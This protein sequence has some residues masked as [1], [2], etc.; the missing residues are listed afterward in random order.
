MQLEEKGFFFCII[1]QIVIERS[2]F[3]DARKTYL[4]KLQCVK[5]ILLRWHYK[6]RENFSNE[7]QVGY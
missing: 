1:K 6:K 2:S 5:V 4:K 3:V 7:S